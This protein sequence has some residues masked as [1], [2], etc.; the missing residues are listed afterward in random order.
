M[1]NYLSDHRRSLSACILFAFVIGGL[2][3]MY[4]WV[5][6]NLQCERSTLRNKLLNCAH[7]SPVSQ[8]IVF[9]MGVCAFPP[10]LVTTVWVFFDGLSH[11]FAFLKRSNK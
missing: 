2:L 7:L 9:A 1:E 8:M 3:F 5:P 6:D 10:L 4:F 11:V